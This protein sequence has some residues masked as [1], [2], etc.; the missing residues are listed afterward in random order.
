MVQIKYS[1]ENHKFIIMV[2][3]N[4]YISDIH[5]YNAKFCQ[6]YIDL[7]KLNEFGKFIIIIFK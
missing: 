6:K 7:K 4:F 5:E 1:N 2:D 3:F